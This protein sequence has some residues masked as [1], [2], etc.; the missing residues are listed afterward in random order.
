MKLVIATKNKGKIKEIKRILEQKKIDIEVL[1]LDNFP[2]IDKIEEPYDTFEQNALAKA[3]YVAEKTK[4]ITL[5]DDSGLEVDALGGRPG[6]H[7]ARYAGDDATDEENIKKLLKEMEHIKEDEKRGAQFRCVMVLYSPLGDYVVVNGV[8]RGRIT[9]IP[10]GDMGFG[11]DPVFFDEK[12]GKTAASM[13]L[14]TKN[15]I[16]HRGEALKKLTQILPSFLNMLK[17]NV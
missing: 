14:D 8:W 17:S 3:K 10:M 15:N 16:S 1:G 2:E 7:S 6:V 9:K 11:Y 4:F 12:L 5:S 13:D